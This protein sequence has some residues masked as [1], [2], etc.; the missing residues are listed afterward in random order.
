MQYPAEYPSCQ[1]LL[2]WVHSGMH[3]YLYLD[4][5]TSRLLH[6]TP[7]KW[8]LPNWTELY[9][10]P[11]FPESQDGHLDRLFQGV[12]YEYIPERFTF[13]APVQR[14]GER[15]HLKRIT[16]LYISGLLSLYILNSLTTNNKIAFQNPL[17]WRGCYLCLNG[18]LSVSV[19]NTIQRNAPK[20]KPHV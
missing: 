10:P 1:M 18:I 6:A 2:R 14:L 7:R 8:V 3:C 12:G 15:L 16:N 4:G 19:E 20:L 13:P 17:T 9:R 11:L 5:Y